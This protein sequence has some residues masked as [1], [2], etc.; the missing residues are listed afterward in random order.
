MHRILLPMT[1]DGSW[2]WCW[3]VDMWRSATLHVRVVHA[4][5][6][7]TRSIMLVPDSL[8][9]G[10]SSSEQAILSMHTPSV[11]DP[12]VCA[13]HFHEDP[14]ACPP[15]SAERPAVCTPA[16]LL[17]AALLPMNTVHWVLQ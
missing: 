8:T 17:L 10:F 12:A 13:P 6:G 1:A 2:D 5:A 16:L 7:L 4:S 3:M 15:H 9:L 11:E 14:A